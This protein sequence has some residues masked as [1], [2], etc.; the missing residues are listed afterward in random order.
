MTSRTWT[1]VLATV[2]AVV[3]SPTGTRAQCC[4]SSS[5]C[6]C[7]L[8]GTI[9]DTCTGLQWE[10][11]TTAVG[12]GANPADRHDVDNVYSWAGCCN[13]NC[14]AD[15]PFCQPNAA[16]AATCAANG[17]TVGCNTCASGTCKVDVF[18]QG[19]TI[20]TVWDW[21]NQ[22]NA[23]N[24]AG[25]NDWRLPSEAGC[26][27]CWAHPGLC[28][29]DP[30]ELESLLLAPH[31][32]EISNPCINSIFGSTSS[33]Y[34]WSASGLPDTNGVWTVAFGFGFVNNETMVY[35]HHVRAV[36]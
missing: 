10:K 3:V 4:L 25:H 34:Y 19:V 8:G 5:G 22:V 14:F 33:G 26:N 6:F 18:N 2:V 11:K 9:K 7:D 15:N 20:T 21:L 24:F 35:G 23:E 30:H 16:A 27:S 29:C 12:S 17:G 13:G 31:P 28:A 36:R 32:C 1:L